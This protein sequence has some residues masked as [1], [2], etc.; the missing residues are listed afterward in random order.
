MTIQA[1]ITQNTENESQAILLVECLNAQPNNLTFSLSRRRGQARFL[2]ATGWQAESYQWAPTSVQFEDGLARIEF[3]RPRIEASD[4]EQ[5]GGACHLMLEIHSDDIDE[6]VSSPVY[7]PN[8]LIL[9]PVT[10]KTDTIAVAVDAETKENVEP[11]VLQVQTRK[12][13]RL[14]TPG[15]AAL[16]LLG[17]VAAF[18]G[19]LNISI[20][21]NTSISADVTVPESSP[22]PNVEDTNELESSPQQQ[23][24]LHTQSVE[25]Q[26]LSL[27]ELTPLQILSYAEQ[28]IYDQDYERAK[29]LCDRASSSHAQAAL[30]CGNWFDPVFTSEQ[31]SPQ[32]QLAF[33][34]YQA[35]IDFGAQPEEELN[36][37][38]DWLKTEKQA[39]DIIEMIDIIYPAR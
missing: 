12:R 4:A 15:L 3:P 26:T 1:K 31:Q 17:G 2:S 28:A 24:D 37:L 23:Q 38:R 16:L 29:S 8:G 27:D 39:P 35:A 7:W 34:Y 10:P 25:T 11:P 19:N 5:S 21:S 36:D 30:N 9:N 14:L 13:N 18:V 22:F 32:P 33:K 6:P 20:H